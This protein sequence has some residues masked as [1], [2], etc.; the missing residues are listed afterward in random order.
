MFSARLIRRLEITDLKKGKAVFTHD[1]IV[2][3]QDIPTECAAGQ[4]RKQPIEMV[5]PDHIFVDNLDST[6][7]KWPDL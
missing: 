1:S 6:K 4:G 2:V 3:N 7:G 5:I